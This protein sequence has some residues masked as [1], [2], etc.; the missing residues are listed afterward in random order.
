MPLPK[1]RE[2]RYDINSEIIKAV[3]GRYITWRYYRHRMLPDDYAELLDDAAGA[4]C[5]GGEL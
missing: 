3:F 1:R 2:L 5:A 4:Y